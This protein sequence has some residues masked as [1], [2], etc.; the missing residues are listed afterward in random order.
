MF[1][2]LT[3]SFG[4][5]ID[6]YPHPEADWEGFKALIARLNAG[7][8]RIFSPVESASAGP[9]HWIDLSRVSRAGAG[10]SKCGCVVM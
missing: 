1:H 2:F 9:R 8:D 4:G 7:T 10:G 5:N 6:D 3:H